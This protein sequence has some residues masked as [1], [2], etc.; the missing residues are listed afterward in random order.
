MQN[1]PRL[2]NLIEKT[3]QP[4]TTP[5][6][7]PPLPPDGLVDM[8]DLFH[9]FFMDSFGKIAFGAELGSLDMKDLPFTAAFD[10]SQSILMARFLDPLYRAREL[11]FPQIRRDFKTVREFGLKV[12][13]DRWQGL[14]KGVDGDLISL[15]FKYKDDEGRSLN[16]D[17][18]VD[19]V[20]N[21]LIAGRD[22]TAQALSWTLYCLS[23][24]PRCVEIMLD[25]INRVID[26]G[27]DIPTYEQVKELKYTKAVFNETLRLYPSV[28]KDTK[29]AIN[30]DVLPDGTKVAAGT[31][32]VWFAYGMGRSE[33]IWEDALL[34]KPESKVSIR[35]L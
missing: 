4:P 18:M 25:E 20:I 34:F 23:K 17:Q 13:N 33:R 26:A 22:T 12:I 35:R 21:F 11:F 10:R 19:Q 3:L 1:V 30:D 15:F 28:A 5:S 7:L 27:Q 29:V 6:S 9:R 16:D 2:L 8:H 32:F 24:N 31:L 14:V